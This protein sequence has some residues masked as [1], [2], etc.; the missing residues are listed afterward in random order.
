MTINP[1][2]P[3]LES[4]NIPSCSSSTQCSLCSVPADH[5]PWLAAII[6]VVAGLLL[7]GIELGAAVVFALH[8]LGFLTVLVAVAMIA[9]VILFVTALYQM[10]VGSRRLAAVIEGVEVKKRNVQ[11]EAEIASLRSQLEES[12]K[13]IEEQKLLIDDGDAAL[14][15]AD[16]I[17]TSQERVIRFTS[18]E[19]ESAQEEISHKKENE[20]LREELALLDQELKLQDVRHI[21]ESSGLRKILTNMQK[22]GTLEEQDEENRH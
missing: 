2:T 13:T 4:S 5:Y 17:I 19:L 22:Y 16:N 14:K 21:R 20:N 10:V 18:E 7:L 12:Q 9:S 11:L 15:V 1:L 8:S 6:T 3:N